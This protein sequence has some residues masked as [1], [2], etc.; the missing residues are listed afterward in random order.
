MDFNF[1]R[2]CTCIH[3]VSNFQIKFKINLT[4]VVMNEGLSVSSLLT[5]IF[6]ITNIAISMREKFAHSTVMV[7]HRFHTAI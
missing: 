2:K 5:G 3:H 1:R 7:Q 6:I 4:D